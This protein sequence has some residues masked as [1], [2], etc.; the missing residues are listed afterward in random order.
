MF[1][2]LRCSGVQ[3]LYLSLINHSSRSNAIRISPKEGD[4]ISHLYSLVP[5]KKGEEITVSYLPLDCDF[6]FARAQTLL[7]DAYGITENEE[8]LE[9]VKLTDRFKVLESKKGGVAEQVVEALEAE[10]DDLFA[11]EVN[12]DDLLAFKEKALRV[13]NPTH[14]VILRLHKFMIDLCASLLA[15]HEQSD[16]TSK[17]LLHERVVDA[18]REIDAIYAHYL[19]E[20]HV[21]RFNTYGTPICSPVV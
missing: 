3:Y 4:S 18:V 1:L 10:L 8:L 12:V 7:H 20:N 21:E 11:N 5:I 16:A 17:V 19:S 2:I 6:S 15:Y 9:W 13:V 14:V